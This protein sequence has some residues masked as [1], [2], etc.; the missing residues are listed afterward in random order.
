MHKIISPFVSFLL[1]PEPNAGTI[2]RPQALFGTLL[3]WDFQVFLLQ[4]SFYA[5]IADTPPICPQEV[6]HR[7][8]HE[9]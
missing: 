5:I 8:A 7:L 4:N 6:G 9:H 2:I 3:C 1:W